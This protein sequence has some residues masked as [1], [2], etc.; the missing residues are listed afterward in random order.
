L[1]LVEIADSGITGWLP[2]YGL[3][4]GRE[5]VWGVIGTDEE[6]E[7]CYWETAAYIAPTVELR[8]G[9]QLYDAPEGALLWSLQGGDDVLLLSDCG[10]G[11]LHVG[12]IDAL[13]SYFVRAEDCTFEE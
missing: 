7:W 6:D 5:Q 10:N 3:L 13:S 2:A 12:E 4:L 8:S 9:T 11:W 1:A